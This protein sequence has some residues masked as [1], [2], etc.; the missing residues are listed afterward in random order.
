MIPCSG[1]HH[2]AEIAIPDE[3]VENPVERLDQFQVEG[4]PLF[5]PVQSEDQ[6]G[7][8]AFLEED[9]V[10]GGYLAGFTRE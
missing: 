9:G 5:R 7:V 10:H 1:D 4:I 8:P 3:V 2:R 6:D